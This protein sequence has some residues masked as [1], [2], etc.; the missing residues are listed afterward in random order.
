MGAGSGDKDVS[1]HHH[2]AL[3]AHKVAK[4]G[5]EAISLTNGTRGDYPNPSHRIAMCQAINTGK[6]YPSQISDQ[7]HMCAR[8]YLP[9]SNMR[10]WVSQI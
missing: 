8:Q 2:K 1:D 5:G 4:E 9:I 3:K 6:D 7:S 10:W